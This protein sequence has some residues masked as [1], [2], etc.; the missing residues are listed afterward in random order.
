ME[1]GIV[2]AVVLTVVGTL[3]VLVLV[4][5]VLAGGDVARLQLA[6]RA[7]LRTMTQE[8]FA[9]KVQGLFAPP[10]PVKPSGA[11][12][13]LLTLMQREGRLIDFI[14]EDVQQYPPEQ[15]AQIGA[16]VRDIHKGCQ[17]VLKEHLVLEPVM[18][19]AREGETVEVPTGFDP[20]N[21]RLVGNVTGSPPFKGTLQHHGWRVKEIK[22]AE[23]A[24]GQD[25]FVLQPA[26]VE[27]P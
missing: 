27:I 8:A 10:K 5:F 4:G 12:L 2:L 20:A 22:L 11:P 26:E 1:T 17:K 18:G 21:I 19:N 3:A 7:M 9:E 25:E 13:R 23:P 14:L 6:L 24:E 15:N 16:A